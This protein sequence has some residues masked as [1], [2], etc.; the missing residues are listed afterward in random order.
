[1]TKKVEK[2][3]KGP[4]GELKDEKR[5]VS[6]KDNIIGIV[7]KDGL[8]PVLK[9][10]TSVMSINDLQL[11]NYTDEETPGLVVFHGDKIPLW[12]YSFEMLMRGVGAILT[13][14][15]NNMSDIIIYYPLTDYPLF[16]RD[17][18]NDEL[19]TL[20]APFYMKNKKKIA[21]AKPTDT[22][23]A[24]ISVINGWSSTPTSPVLSTPSS[25]IPQNGDKTPSEA[26]SSSDASGGGGDEQNPAEAVTEA[27]E[28]FSS[29]GPTPDT[30][31]QEHEI[32]PCVPMSPPLNPPGINPV[33]TAGVNP[34]TGGDNEQIT[35]TA[36]DVIETAVGHS[37]DSLPP[38]ATPEMDANSVTVLNAISEVRKEN[39]KEYSSYDNVK[40]L[41]V[42]WG[43]EP[44]TTNETIK[45]LLDRNVIMGD[46]T[47]GLAVVGTVE[48]K[49]EEVS[50]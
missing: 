35:P 47:R 16:I 41:C 13:L 37:L 44:K 5:I 7:I 39:G 32:K 42:A 22:V 2:D 21:L 25:P 8:A 48:I 46:T 14:T 43:M 31:K 33:S 30:I 15:G 18:N 17:K 50:E 4:I 29:R 24:I 45:Q 9:R 10:A 40:G 28:T 6:G 20:V 34:T 1:M 49:N 26:S 11:I 19:F 3:K 38:G 12:G 23:S 27:G 36:K